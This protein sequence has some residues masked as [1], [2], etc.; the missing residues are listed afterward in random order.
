MT[1]NP[2]DLI[3]PGLLFALYVAAAI[4]ILLG[5]PTSA[6]V[7]VVIGA[8]VLLGVSLL[9]MTARRGPD[10]SRPE[11]PED[12]ATDLRREREQVGEV[13]AVSQLRKRYPE[14]SLLDATRL[15]RD[16]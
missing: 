13:S 10:H 12:V 3:F 2:R 7:L 16:L 4:C 14:L 1:N 11:I 15:V 8:V 6:L 9:R 5:N